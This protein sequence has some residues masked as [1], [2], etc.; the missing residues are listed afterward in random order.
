MLPGIPE[1]TKAASVRVLPSGHIPPHMHS[2]LEILYLTEGTLTAGLG[3][4]LFPMK[5]GDAALFFP[6]LIHHCQALDPAPGQVLRLHALPETFGVYTDLL[7]TQQPENPV[8]AAESLSEDIPYAM[9][10]LGE[11][12]SGEDPRDDTA[13]NALF[14][15]FVQIL[16]AGTIPLLS[17]SQ[18]PILQD[19]D[20][21][22]RAV[23][24]LS[25]HFRE[26]L[27]LSGMADDLG[28]SQSTLSRIFS[29][30]FHQNFSRCLA[31]VRLQYVTSLLR[32]TDLPVTRIAMDA[33]F[34][35]QATFNR[36]FQGQFHMTP[37][38][39]R[40]EVRAGAGH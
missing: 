15:A 25:E 8:I 5:K 19:Q 3:P 17:L 12:S 24:Y 20:L 7:K 39:Y 26:D 10:R 27:S 40:K 28:I 13:R 37:R 31:G 23:S 21:I 11:L 9:R 4:D 18:R 34:Q 29:G 33:G 30:T 38:D 35:S 2:C 22:S 6:G 32:D 1:E 36:A 16:L 14:Y